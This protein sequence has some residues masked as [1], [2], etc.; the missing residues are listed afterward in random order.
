MADSSGPGDGP[1]PASDDVRQ[2]SRGLLSISTRM[3]SWSRSAR[4]AATSRV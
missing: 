2:G 1:R 4:V 3:W